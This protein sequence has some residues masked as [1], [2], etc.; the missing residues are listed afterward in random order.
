MPATITSQ[1]DELRSGLSVVTDLAIRDLATVSDSVDALI[2][3]IPELVN[4]YGAAA[5][6][7]AAEWYDDL[8]DQQEVPGSFR[9]LVP[10]IADP[11]ADALVRWAV[12]F[13]AMRSLIEGG[14][15]K[16]VLN[17]ARG[18][19]TGSAVADPQARGWQRVGHGDCPLCL[20]LIS[21]GAVYTKASANFASHDACKCTAQPAWGGRGVAVKPFTPSQQSMSDADRARAKAWI[22][23]NL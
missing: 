3:A 16:R 7:L 19:L 4:V 2:E 11:G 1:A 12:G 21:R 15:Q 5:G 14:L 10:E 18:T 6:S 13:V 17:V 8:R 9:A 22:A 23:A 20:M